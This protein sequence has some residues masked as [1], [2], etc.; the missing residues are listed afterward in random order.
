VKFAIFGLLAFAAVTIWWSISGSWSALGSGLM[1]ASQAAVIVILRTE[2]ESLQLRLFVARYAL[3]YG[4]IALVLA[5]NESP[6]E[7]RY[8]LIFGVVMAF[9]A[10][11]AA[12]AAAAWWQISKRTRRER[13]ASA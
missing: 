11:I 8:W 13:A 7:L 6:A 12:C 3:L 4:G 10:V 9:W 1:A 5:G 2:S